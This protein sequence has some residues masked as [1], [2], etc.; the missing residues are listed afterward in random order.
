MQYSVYVLEDG[1]DAADRAVKAFWALESNDVRRYIK[2]MVLKSPNGED[3]DILELLDKRH[4][5]RKANNEVLRR[6]IARHLD[7]SGT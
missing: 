6:I 7:R 2:S 3:T 4:A 1:P 5:E